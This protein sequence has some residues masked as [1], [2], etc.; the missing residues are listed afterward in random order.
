M[1]VTT[2]LRMVMKIYHKYY[3]HFLSSNNHEMYIQEKSMVNQDSEF[4]AITNIL[5]LLLKKSRNFERK[6]SLLFFVLNNKKLLSHMAQISEQINSSNK[7][8]FLL[9]NKKNDY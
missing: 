2:Y 8:S 6:V 4:V 5:D 7:K 3:A 9:P 1:K